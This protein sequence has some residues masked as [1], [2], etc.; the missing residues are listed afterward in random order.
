MPKVY[1]PY[2]DWPQRDRNA[3]LA[4]IQDGDIL[5]GR[6]L[7][8][9]WAVATRTTN[10]QHY[11]RWLGFLTR[12]G[13]L[14]VKKAPASRVTQDT[15]RAYVSAMKTTIAPRTNPTKIA[16]STAELPAWP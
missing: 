5:D 10:I 7:A 15:V 1:L 8:F 13:L 9:H 4:A 16:Y 6:G 2:L 3:W 12:Q 14:D 11:G